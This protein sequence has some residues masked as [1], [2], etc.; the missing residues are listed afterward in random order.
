M[1]SERKHYSP[2]KTSFFGSQEDLESE[3]ILKVSGGNR[4]L[5]RK[6]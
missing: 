1:D 4:F 6:F 3:T 5:N 2:E